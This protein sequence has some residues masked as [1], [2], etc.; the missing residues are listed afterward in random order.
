MRPPDVSPDGRWLAYTS[1]ESGQDE[2]YVRPFPERGGRTLE[3]LA[4]RR[5]H[6]PSGDRIVVNCSTSSTLA[7]VMMVSIETEPTFSAGN[8]RPLAVDGPYRDRSN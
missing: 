8:P 5:I 3:D 7:G 2:V 4:R 1:D 6:A